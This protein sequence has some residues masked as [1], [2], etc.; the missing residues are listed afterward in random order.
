MRERLR[1][2]DAAARSRVLSHGP[3]LVRALAG[4]GHTPFPTWAARR[5]KRHGSL[6]QGRPRT[7]HH[8]ACNQ[9]RFL[10]PAGPLTLLMAKHRPGRR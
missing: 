10:L 5:R 8:G 4:P 1:A 6:P 3:F 9:E 7:F 2:L